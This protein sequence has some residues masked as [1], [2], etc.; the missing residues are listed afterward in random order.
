[1]E[2]LFAEELETQRHGDHR[3]EMNEVKL[4]PEETPSE[5]PTRSDQLKPT[6]PNLFFSSL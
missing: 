2:N 5:W 3:E 4:S 1:L 6:F